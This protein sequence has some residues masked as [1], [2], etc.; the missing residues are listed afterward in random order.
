L[1]QLGD[2]D[3]AVNRLRE[4]EQ[5]VDGLVEKESLPTAARFTGH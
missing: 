5:L 1:A 4:G 3:E 2:A